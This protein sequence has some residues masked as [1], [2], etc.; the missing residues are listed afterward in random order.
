MMEFNLG[1]TGD[2]LTSDGKPCF[3]QQP[4]DNLHKEKKIIRNRSPHG[5]TNK[6]IISIEILKKSWESKRGISERTR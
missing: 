1:I 5:S 2:L 4:L 3:G 6:R